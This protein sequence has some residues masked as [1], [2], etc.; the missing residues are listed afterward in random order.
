MNNAK[1]IFYTFPGVHDTLL[2]EEMPRQR[3]CEFQPYKI[4]INSFPSCL[5]TC[6][7]TNHI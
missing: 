2:G 3:I 1:Y 6:T 4:V 5:L 7:L